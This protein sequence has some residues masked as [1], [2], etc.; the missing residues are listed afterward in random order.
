L[1]AAAIG[2]I[3]RFLRHKRTRDGSPHLVAL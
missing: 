3:V 1:C 2:S